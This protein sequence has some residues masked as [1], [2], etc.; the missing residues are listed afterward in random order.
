MSGRKPPANKKPIIYYNGFFHYIEGNESLKDS[1]VQYAL[2][3]IYNLTKS[4]G[5]LEHAIIEAI[6]SVTI[7]ILDDNL[8]VME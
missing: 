3:Q 4:P 8:L 2:F 1:E 6:G 7:N 5:E